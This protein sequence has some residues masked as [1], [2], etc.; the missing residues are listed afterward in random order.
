MPSV[1]YDFVPG[2]TVYVI[3]S[4]TIKSGTVVQVDVKVTDVTQMVAYWVSIAGQT[5]AFTDNIYATCQAAE[6]YQ[7]ANFG[8]NAALI[9]TAYAPSGSPSPAT[10]DAS[11]LIDGTVT[12]PVSLV[13]NGPTMTFQDVISGINLALGA[14]GT[15]MVMDGNVRVQSATKNATSSVAITDANLFS[16]LTG[17][18]Q[19]D[20][21]VP[22]DAVG[23]L[24]AL[25]STVC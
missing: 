1:S 23:A 7:I 21:A 8:G 9:A 12:I 6:G 13:G 20:T 2:Q 17:F 3:D 10:L 15:A 18:V 24:E 25:G 16:S 14:Y 11:F 22:G 19:I 4:G 5:T